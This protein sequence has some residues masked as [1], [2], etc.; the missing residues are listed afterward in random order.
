MRA[1]SSAVVNVCP[2]DIA[3]T[4]RNRTGCTSS[5]KGSTSA[6][7]GIAVLRFDMVTYAHGAELAADFTMADEYVPH[8]VA[9]VELLRAHAAV[10]AD[11][12]FVVG[13]SMGG[14]V[15]PRV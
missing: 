15:A 9:A 6:S 1:Q 13:H 11:R 4:I 12:V 8:A 14:K 3:C 2:P 7:R 5:S 10:D